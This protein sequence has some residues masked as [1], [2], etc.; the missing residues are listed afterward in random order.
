[1]KSNRKMGNDFEKEFC[2][3]MS[4]EGYWVHLMTQDNAGQP[5]DVI[6]VKNGI[7]ILVDCKNCENEVFDL[8]RIE[9]NQI[10]AMQLWRE[11]GNWHC[12]F[13][14]KWKGEIRI[15]T[16]TDILE[17]LPKYNNVPVEVFER[18][19]VPISMQLALMEVIM[20]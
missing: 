18:K 8:R 16:L 20:G 3:L 13:A 10:T 2:E 6:A 19:S 12:W 1:M 7:P 14:V 15:V 11:C 9:G 17:W 4:E 5:A